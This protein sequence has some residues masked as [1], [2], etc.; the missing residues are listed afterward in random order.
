MINLKK[1]RHCYFSCY[2]EYNIGI[3]SLT[4]TGFKFVKNILSN[5]KNEIT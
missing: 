4:K 5:K 2:A 3:N 1:C